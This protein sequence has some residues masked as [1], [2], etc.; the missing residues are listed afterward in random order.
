MNRSRKALAAEFIGA[1]ALIFLGAGAATAL[2]DEQLTAIAFAHGLTIM[3]FASAFSD[4]SSC[5]INPAVTV[6]LTAAGEFLRR[7]VN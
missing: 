2:G 4:I 1:F 3:V 5:H 6:G 7:H